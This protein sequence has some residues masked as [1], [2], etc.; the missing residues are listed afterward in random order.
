MTYSLCG[1]CYGIIPARLDYIGMDILLNKTCP[2][3]GT[4]E[5]L[6][7]TTSDFQKLIFNMPRIDLSARDGM[8]ALNVTN[9]C[10]VRCPGCYALPDQSK[11]RSLAS[12]I[13]EAKGI[14]RTVVGLMGAEPTMRRDL[15]QLIRE[16]SIQT[17]KKIFIY[18][19]GIKLE[20]KSY[21][22][23]LAENGLTSLALSLHLP[24]YL[25]PKA[26]ISKVKALENI[27][28]TSIALDHISISLKDES[29]IGIAI[30]AIMSLDYGNMSNQYVRLRS[31]SSIGG[32]RNIPMSMAYL[33]DLVLKTCRVRGLK[34][35][36]APFTHHRYA[37]M[38]NIEGRL[39]VLVN[40]PTVEDID[41]V[42]AQQG[43]IGALF[44]PEIGET[45]ILHQVILM[46]HVRSG[47]TLPPPPP[48]GCS[49]DISGIAA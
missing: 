10:N 39:V 24:S 41:L 44:V 38:L 30:Q 8:T 32:K 20:N 37:I 49:P 17:N 48:L 7:D 22:D 40:W 14:K 34:V 33:L 12:I 1:Q 35:E 5:V 23:E 11:D 4:Q 28:G 18:T 26:F 2:T 13:K 43:P 9:R 6:L 36:P 27:K 46:E 25:G 31:P 21:V 45:Q 15:P 47:G 16:L 29:E 19:N 3:H 42:E